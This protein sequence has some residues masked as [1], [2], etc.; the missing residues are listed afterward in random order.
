MYCGNNDL[1]RL[2]ARM[3]SVRVFAVLC[4]VTH[5]PYSWAHTAYA[6]NWWPLNSAF[7]YRGSK[8]I[9]HNCVHTERKPG[10]RLVYA[11]RWGR[12]IY[13]MYQQEFSYHIEPYRTHLWPSTSPKAPC[14]FSLKEETHIHVH[15]IM[16][17]N[18]TMKNIAWAHKVPVPMSSGIT[19]ERGYTTWCWLHVPLRITSYTNLQIQR[20]MCTCIY[21]IVSCTSYSKQCRF[22]AGGIIHV[23]MYM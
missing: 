5:Q 16:K 20:Y 9:S 14:I 18:T 23:H 22:A 21:M 6:S 17:T 8:A 11:Y 1:H 4:L 2:Y 3:Y 10:M 12:C 15:Y 7:F 19:W 13:M